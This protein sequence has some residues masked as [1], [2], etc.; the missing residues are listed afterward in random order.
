MKNLARIS[1]GTTIHVVQ[2][3]SAGLT[4]RAISWLE[5]LAGQFRGEFRRF[6]ASGN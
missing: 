1:P 4:S 2:F 6:E 5:I 3:A